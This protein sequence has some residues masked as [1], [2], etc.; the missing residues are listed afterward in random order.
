MITNCNCSERI[1]C[2]CTVSF[3]TYSNNLYS[4]LSVG[5]LVGNGCTL[6][7]YV[8][9]WY[10]D[11][12]HAMVSS[13]IIKP[14]IDAYHP[15]TGSA[16]IPVK[17]GT[18]VP[19]LRY[20]VIGGEK[21]FPTPKNCQKWCSDL[22]GNLPTINVLP[23]TC[24]VVSGSPASGYTFRM[25]YTTTQDYSYATRTVLWEMPEDGS[26]KYLAVQFY[27][28]TVIDVVHVYYKDETTPLSYFA[29]GTDFP[30]TDGAADPAWI[31][32]QS[33]RF[34]V[35][36]TDRAYQAGDY[37]TIKVTP[38]SNP[39]TQWVLDLKC[40]N[41]NAF[42]CDLFPLTL[43]D[44]DLDNVTISFDNANCKYLLSFPIGIMSP[45]Y[46]SSNLYKY[47]SIAKWVNTGD[48]VLVDS[49]GMVTLTMWDKIFCTA[50]ALHTHW[51]TNSAGLISYTK[52]GSVFTFTFEHVDDYNSY[53][54]WYNGNRTNWKFSSFVNDPSNI[55]YYKIFQISW[56]EVLTYCGDTYTWRAFQFHWNSP[57]TFNDTA[58]TMVI[59]FN[60]ITNQYPNE[61]PRQKCDNTYET[62]NTWVTACQNTRSAADWSGSTRCRE[63]RPVNGV[64]IYQQIWN[65]VIK[66]FIIAY[67]IPVKKIENVCNMPGWYEFSTMAYEYQFQLI[68][69]R[70][71]IT[72]VNDRA[73]NFRMSSQLV[74]E[75]GAN[76]GI[77]T[78]IYERQNGIQIFP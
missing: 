57:V 20:V 74:R 28:Y 9:D 36:L 38:S 64:W 42:Q 47:L 32:F 39:N 1:E 49:T 40:L 24:D 6:D 53:K 4:V 58:K 17:A 51:H 69:L 63:G 30:Y 48:A 45:S 67:G 75:T 50:E 29:V 73:N 26:M 77:W 52:I 66:D 59:E 3:D 11:G 60:A 41:A 10:R 33:V 70:I 44:L 56:Q 78:R 37:L 7:D 15:F 68:N 22:Q 13:K 23:L 35:N 21:V 54:T 19:V 18:W 12:V 55:N 34:V 5:N 61:Q 16:A 8:I 27:G 62:I 65:D 31:D 43:R 71:E 25:S 14:G 76:T 2:S 46:W 72:N